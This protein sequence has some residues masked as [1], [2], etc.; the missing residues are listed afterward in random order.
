MSKDR[1]EPHGAGL[2]N[3][4]AIAMAPFFPAA[5]STAAAKVCR[6]VPLEG[7][8]IGAFTSPLGGLRRSASMI[9]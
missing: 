4:R 7:A 2:S 5:T 1:R 6:S 8:T 3:T 9:S